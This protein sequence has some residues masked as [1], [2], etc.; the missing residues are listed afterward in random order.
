MPPN[1]ICGKNVTKKQSQPVRPHRK[2]RKYLEEEKHLVVVYFRTLHIHFQKKTKI[3]ILIGICSIVVCHCDLGRK[4]VQKCVGVPR[5]NW[6]HSLYQIHLLKV[7]ASHL[8]K[9]L[10]LLVTADCKK[11]SKKTQLISRSPHE[12]E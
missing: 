7:T 5:G 9:G 4:K 2:S 8:K 12:I 1:F 11:I 3:L 6:S 10:C